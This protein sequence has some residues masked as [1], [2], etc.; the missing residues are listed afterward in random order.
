MAQPLIPRDSL[1][2]AAL[3]DALA[4]R[5]EASYDEDGYQDTV[6]ADHLYDQ[7]AY[8]ERDVELAADVLAVYA[9]E[10]L[11]FAA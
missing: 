3:E 6:E 7:H 9:S 10:V 11:R 5:L 8:L 2:G 1:I 4:A